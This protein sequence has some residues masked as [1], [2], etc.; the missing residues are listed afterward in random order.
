MKFFV[1]VN[2]SPIEYLHIRCCKVLGLWWVRTSQWSSVIKS[3]DF[4]P[5]FRGLIIHTLGP[6]AH[7]RTPLCS[8]SFDSPERFQDYFSS[9]RFVDLGKT[10]VRVVKFLLRKDMFPKHVFNNFWYKMWLRLSINSSFL[11]LHV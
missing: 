6:T 7:E 8:H 9:R 3:R 11:I 1:V 4:R 2:L 10:E 5:P